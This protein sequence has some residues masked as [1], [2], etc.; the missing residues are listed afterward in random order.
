MV[1]RG[2]PRMVDERLTVFDDRAVELDERHRSRDSVWIELEE[3]ELDQLRFALERVPDRYWSRLPKLTML[4]AE[5]SLLDLF[6]VNEFETPDR[7]FE[8]RRG[9]RR[10][11]GDFRNPDYGVAPLVKWLD[12]LR[13][14]A[15]RLRTR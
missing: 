11:A 15:V 2:F 14:R 3:P 4:S 9:R 1:A 5:A 10:I 13:L 7:L 12:A 8:L 6:T